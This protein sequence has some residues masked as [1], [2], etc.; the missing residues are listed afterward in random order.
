[1]ARRCASPRW[2]MRRYTTSAVTD[3]RL[4]AHPKSRTG[5]AAVLVTELI[6]ALFLVG[7]PQPAPAR[8]VVA[9]PS[10]L[11]TPTAASS[12]ET[13]SDGRTVHLI[14]LGGTRTAS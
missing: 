3:R 9:A 5:L 2:T 11:T 4:S 13:L 7:R 10:S 12:T 1:M 6:C 8:P 14:G